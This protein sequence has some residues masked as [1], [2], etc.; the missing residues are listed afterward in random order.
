[1]PSSTTNS[2]CHEMPRRAA[3]ERASSG[4]DQLAQGRIAV[5]DG[6]RPW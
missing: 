5:D 1:M 2:Q 4:A 3:L 6:N